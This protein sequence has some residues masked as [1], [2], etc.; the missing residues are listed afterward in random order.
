MP[1]VLVEL[2]YLSNAEQEKLLTGDN[3]QATFVQ[4][5]YETVLRFL[6]SA[7]GTQ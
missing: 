6:D 3:F 1:A 5:L 2:G 7:R 4:A